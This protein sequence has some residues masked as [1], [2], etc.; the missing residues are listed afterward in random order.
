MDFAMRSCQFCSEQIFA[1]SKRCIHCLKEFGGSKAF[2]V[3]GKTKTAAM[4][5]SLAMM[6]S[7]AVSTVFRHPAEPSIVVPVAVVNQSARSTPTVSAP[8]SSISVDES[9]DSAGSFNDRMARDSIEEMRQEILRNPKDYLAYE[10]RGWFYFKELGEGRKAIKDLTMAIA[11]RPKWARP[12]AE[13]AW[14]YHFLGNDRK[15]LAD[16]RRAL[17]REPDNQQARDA[18]EAVRQGPVR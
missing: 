10:G 14:V 15:A 17:R 7:L 12:Y 5:I 1:D 2:T 6:A 3:L 18:V 16:A 13:R 8:A 4:H 11:L 9:A